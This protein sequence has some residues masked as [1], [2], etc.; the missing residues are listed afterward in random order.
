MRI[1]GHNE[2]F[3]GRTLDKRRRPEPRKRPISREALGLQIPG[4]DGSMGDS[5]LVA[6]TIRRTAFACC[7]R[8]SVAPPEPEEGEEAIAPRTLS[9]QAF[10]CG[11]RW[12]LRLRNKT[13]WISLDWARPREL[14]VGMGM[15]QQ[16]N[17]GAEMTPASASVRSRPTRI[18]RLSDLRYWVENSSWTNIKAQQALK[19]RANGCTSRAYL[20]VR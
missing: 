18:A 13:G 1:N 3:D 11:R 6:W 4:L 2:P 15:N 9:L 7:M 14:I 12:R 17:A 16:A 20:L 10:I 19:K 8:L 5:L